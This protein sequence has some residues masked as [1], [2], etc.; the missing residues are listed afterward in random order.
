[1]VV[2]LEAIKLILYYDVDLG[3]HAVRRPKLG[4]CHIWCLAGVQDF[5]GTH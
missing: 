4:Q 3:G 1:M 5:F 2:L